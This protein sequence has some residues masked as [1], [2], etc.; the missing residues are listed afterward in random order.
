MWGE[1]LMV[2]GEELM[3]CGGGAYVLLLV[4]LMKEH[5]LLPPHHKL[6]PTYD[7]RLLLVLVPEHRRDLTSSHLRLACM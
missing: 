7:T 5:K 4:P 3:V 2:W 1:E 6:L